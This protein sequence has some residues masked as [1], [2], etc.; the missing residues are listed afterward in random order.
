MTD[1]SSGGDGV[2]GDGDGDNSKEHKARNDRDV[3]RSDDG[4]LTMQ[5][6]RMQLCNQH[7]L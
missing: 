3:G 4:K 6:C 7:I 2:E 5:Y 1:D